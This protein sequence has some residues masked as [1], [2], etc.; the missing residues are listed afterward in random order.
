MS[1]TTPCC[2]YFQRFC[3]VELY[4]T[5]RLCLNRFR[6]STPLIQN[7]Q[8]PLACEYRN[9]LTEFITVLAEADKTRQ[10]N[11]Y[12]NNYCTERVDYEK[13]S[14]KLIDIHLQGA[15][16]DCLTSVATV[17]STTVTHRSSQSVRVRAEC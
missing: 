1:R 3:S 9:P 4:Q 16:L 17:T 13:S 5:V 12:R 7:K 2:K 14:F 10:G 6:F 11:T 15:L 8:V